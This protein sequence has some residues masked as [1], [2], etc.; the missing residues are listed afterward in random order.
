MWGSGAETRCSPLNNV[1]GKS[2]MKTNMGLNLLHV[3]SWINYED[4]DQRV[5]YSGVLNIKQ[6]FYENCPGAV[7]LH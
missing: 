3:G 1:T 7:S 4:N 2:I 5:K 6:C